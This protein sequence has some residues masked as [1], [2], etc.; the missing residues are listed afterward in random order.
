MQTKFK[1]LSKTQKAKL[2]ILARKGY[3][4]ESKYGNTDLAFTEWRRDQQQQAVGCS[5]LTKCIQSDYLPLLAHFQSL[6][7][8]DGEAFKTHLKN[9]PATDHAD[10]EDTPE[11]R[12]QVIQL[13]EKTIQGSK[14]KIAYV[15]AI[16]RNQYRT[17][18]LENL[19]KDKL[20]NLLI[21]IKSR[22]SKANKK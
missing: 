18:K 12:L 21:T 19:S 4:I 3:E 22:V 13:I 2:S 9:Q 16:A 6:T 5:S 15:C 7:G 8:Q 1:P 20:T 14:F 17:T 11:A 10:E